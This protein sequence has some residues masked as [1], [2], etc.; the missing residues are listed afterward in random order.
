VGFL[1]K[2]KPP[3]LAANAG[4]ARKTKHMNNTKNRV[5]TRFARETRFPVTPVVAEP[6]TAA[7]EN[8]L[9][10]LKERLLRQA[11]EETNNTQLLAPL[12]RA[13]ND[14]TALAWTAGYPLL[15]LPVLFQEKA[16]AARLHTAKQQ[17]ILERTQMAEAA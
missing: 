13:A 4:A 15:L 7:R 17:S 12:Q 14:A 1:F 2:R 5:R 3:S 9:E 11:L 16:I 8:E 6:F 10:R